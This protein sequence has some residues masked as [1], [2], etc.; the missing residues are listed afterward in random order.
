V[1]KANEFPSGVPHGGDFYWRLNRAH[2]NCLEN[3]PIFRRGSCSSRRSAGLRAPLLD[4]LARTYLCA[5]IGQSITHVSSGSVIAVNVAFHLLPGA[6]RVPD[7]DD[8]DH[9]ERGLRPAA[10]ARDGA[11]QRRRAL[12]GEADAAHADISAG[13]CRA[14]RPSTPSGEQGEYDARQC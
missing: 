10:R 12:R 1:K 9:L 14:S 4:T 6:G 7:L 13:Q 5:R 3:L 11:D 2:L 8:P